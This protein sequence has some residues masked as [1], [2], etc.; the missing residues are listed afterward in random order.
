[1]KNNLF[2]LGVLAVMLT[3]AFALI[4]CGTPEGGSTGDGKLDLSGTISISPN[5]DVTI[6]MELTAN[7]SGSETVAY[8]WKKDG[9]NVGTNSD[10]YTPT[11]A[12]SYTVTVS[13]TGYNS[14]TSAAVTVPPQAPPGSINITITIGDTDAGID[15]SLIV[16]GVLTLSR[17]SD[18]VTLTLADSDQYD[19]GSI[20]WRVQNTA[21]TGSGA[22]FELNASSTVYLTGKEYFV[23]VE[24]LKGGV[25]HDYTI[26]F[27]VEE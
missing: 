18:P 1:M 6:N 9:S 10:K 16:A 5:T 17:N 22:E 8:Q 14:K 2:N 15:D 13:A 27:K 11:E 4:G 24:A 20:R 19:D 25:P 21:I 23:T 12:G 3:F 26:T 7:Y